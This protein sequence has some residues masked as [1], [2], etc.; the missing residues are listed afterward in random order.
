MPGGTDRPDDQTARLSAA[1][2]LQPL[3]L[4]PVQLLLHT[5]AGRPERIAGADEPPTTARLL[6]PTR[7]NR[8]LEK[9][10]GTDPVLP[11]PPAPETAPPSPYAFRRRHNAD[12]DEKR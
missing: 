8:R 9:R 7:G 11:E 6:P 10:N 12:G 2:Y 1:K 3:L 4:R 5:S